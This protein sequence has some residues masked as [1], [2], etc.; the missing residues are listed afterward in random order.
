MLDKLQSFKLHLPYLRLGHQ[1]PPVKREGGYV[2]GYPACVLLRFQG[3]ND[4]IIRVRNKFERGEAVGWVQRADVPHRYLAEVGGAVEE[5]V[6]A[7]PLVCSLLVVLVTGAAREKE[8][9]LEALAP[10]R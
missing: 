10:R 8:P 4:L 2:G 3:H 1:H 7:P 6:G 9:A 5:E